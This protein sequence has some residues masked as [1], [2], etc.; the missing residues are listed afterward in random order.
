MLRRKK[1]MT[2]LEELN[3]AYKQIGNSVCVPVIRRIAERIVRL[4]SD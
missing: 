3:D 1:Q 4:R 2:K